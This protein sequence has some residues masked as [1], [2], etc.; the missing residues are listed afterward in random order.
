MLLRHRRAQSRPRSE[1][2]A[3]GTRDPEARHV[4]LQPSSS[5]TCPRN[6]NFLAM[7]TFQRWLSCLS[8]LGASV[9]FMQESYLGLAWKFLSLMCSLTSTRLG[10]ANCP[11]TNV[12]MPRES[13]PWQ[14]NTCLRQRQA[15]GCRNR[16]LTTSP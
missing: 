10:I 15:T 4:Q 14:Q 2:Q 5:R 13:L 6:A 3:R 12:L 8:I 16:K 9:L 11:K 7:L 1:S